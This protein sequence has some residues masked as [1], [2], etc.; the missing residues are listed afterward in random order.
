MDTLKPA[1]NRP[2]A[3]R[4]AKIR[5]DTRPG[6]KTPK[7]SPAARRLIRAA[8][9]ATNGNQ[10]AAARLLR[11]P[12]QAQLRKMLAGDIR[13]T[14]AMLAAL[15]RA[16]ARAREAWALVRPPAAGRADLNAAAILSDLDAIARRVAGL[17]QL[18]RG[19]DSSEAPGQ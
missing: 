3:A 13:D 1:R 12:N 11:L 14:P 9:R 15:A 4:V 19:A 16:E 7:S 5:P 6:A 17:A 18:V 8:L 2:A 10:R